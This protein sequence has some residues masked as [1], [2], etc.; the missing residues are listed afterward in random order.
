[1]NILGLELWQLVL[2]ATTAFGAQIVGGLAGYGTGLLL[3]LV[4]VPIIGA[5]AIVPVV[6]L[7]ALITNPTRII[8]YREHLD[9]R[10]ALVLTAFA[11]P[12]GMVGA[13]F[14]TLLSSRGATVLVGS[15]LIMLVPLRRYLAR[16][17]YRLEGAGIAVGGLTYGLLTGA[18]SGVGVILISM[19]MAMGLTGRQ[20][21]ATDALTSTLVGIFKTGV[22]VAAGALPAKLWLVALLIGVMAMPGTLIARW[23]TE[24]FSARL[25]D[26][27]VEAAIV[28][29][30][31]ALIWRALGA[32]P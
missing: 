30:G 8:V 16:R 6:S 7:S 24:R 15:T 26:A 12:T 17:K 23:L 31:L 9:I 19:L 21:I 22:F 4:L 29:G 1:M 28:I 3:P 5:E 18:M 20:V 32:A 25:H 27:I 11:V 2:I 13:W 10:K 14:Y